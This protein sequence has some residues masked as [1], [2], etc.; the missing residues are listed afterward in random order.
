MSERERPRRTLSPRVLRWEDRTA[1]PMFA[2]SLLFF[3]GWVLSLADTKLDGRQQ[4]L[5][6]GAIGVLWA[7]FIADFLVRLSICGSPL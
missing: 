3:A 5:L 6:L 1:W 7:V 2:L 4:S